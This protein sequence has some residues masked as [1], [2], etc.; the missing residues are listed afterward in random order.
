MALSNYRVGALVAVSDMKLARDFYE[1]KLGLTAQGDDP[2]AGAPISASSRQ[3]SIS[4]PP[5]QAQCH[6]P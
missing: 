5:L 6:L 3:C 1:K 4:F 2:T